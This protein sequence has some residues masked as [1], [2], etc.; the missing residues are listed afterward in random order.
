MGVPQQ[1]VGLAAGAHLTWGHARHHSPIKA[2]AAGFADVLL[3]VPRHLLSTQC[4]PG[5]L[6]DTCSRLLLSLEIHF[7][8]LK[9]AVVEKLK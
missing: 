4:Y 6:L 5:Q 9:Q 7:L 1:G 2:L 8:Y 3:P